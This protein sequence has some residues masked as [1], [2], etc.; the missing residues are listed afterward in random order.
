VAY[1]HKGEYDKAIEHVEKAKEQGFEVHPDFLKE[2]E[3]YRNS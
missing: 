2:L 3:P 1:Y